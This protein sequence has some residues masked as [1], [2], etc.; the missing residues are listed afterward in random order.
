VEFHLDLDGEGDEFQ[1][2]HCWLP[3]QIQSV[4]ETVAVG[5]Q[6]DGGGEKIPTPSEESDRRWR[7]DPTDGLRPLRATRSDWCVGCG[8]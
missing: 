7:A 4:I 3:Q 2:G 8:R 6:A 1:A 5:M